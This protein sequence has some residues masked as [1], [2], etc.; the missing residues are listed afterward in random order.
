MQ[1]SGGIYSSFPG[2]TSFMPKDDTTVDVTGSGYL[3]N[4]K[5]KLA[6]NIQNAT[7]AAENTIGVSGKSAQTIEPSAT[8]GQ[9][10]SDASITS[11]FTDW[12][13]LGRIVTVFVGLLLFGAGVFLLGKGPAMTVIG[14][15]K[16]FIP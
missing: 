1:Y 9:S 2:I 6:G 7:T 13:D 3:Q 14:T 5:N 15:A 8:V 4:L 16:K 11:P 12:F 10:K